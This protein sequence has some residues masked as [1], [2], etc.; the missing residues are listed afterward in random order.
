MDRLR[1]SEKSTKG[2]LAWRFAFEENLL[3]L[4]R[5]MKAKADPDALV[6]WIACS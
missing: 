1:A 4:L 5:A 6:I 3:P 2:R